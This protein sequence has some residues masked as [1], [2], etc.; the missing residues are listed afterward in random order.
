MPTR[1]VRLSEREDVRLGARLAERDLQGPLVHTVV[2]PY[3]LVQP[4]VVEHAVP[5]L[6][7]VDAV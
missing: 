7:D 2:L 5:V 4:A 1:T 6:I 3:E